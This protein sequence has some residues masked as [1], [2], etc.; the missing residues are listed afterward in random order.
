[1]MAEST[2]LKKVL[3]DNGLD[4][5]TWVPR[6][7]EFGVTKPNQL[8]F[9]KTETIEALKGKK[10][11]DWEADALDELFKIYQTPKRECCH[12]NTGG[13]RRRGGG[14]GE[15]ECG[16]TSPLSKIQS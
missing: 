2:D 11:H 4:A 15:W 16:H 12:E 3:E 5:D 8:K 6:F 13:L 1:M 14:F 7:K 10:D 9:Q